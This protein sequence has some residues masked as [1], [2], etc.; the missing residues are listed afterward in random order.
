MSTLYTPSRYGYMATKSV[1]FSTDYSVKPIQV[2]VVPDLVVRVLATPIFFSGSV[3]GYC[4]PSACIRLGVVPVALAQLKKLQIAFKH[5]FNDT[6]EVAAGV[7]AAGYM[8]TVFAQG[9]S[10]LQ[11]I[12]GFPIFEAV[13]IIATPDKANEFLLYIPMVDNH[14]LPYLIEVMLKFFNHSVF[15]TTDLPDKALVLVMEALL[16]KLVSYAPKGS[17][18]LRFLQAAHFADIPWMFIEQN[19]FQFGYGKKS[20]WLDST[21]TDKTSILATQLARSKLSTA[22]LLRKAGL[23]VPDQYLVTSETEAINAAKKIGYPVVVKPLSEDNG[24]GVEARLQSEQ[25]VKKA[26]LGA[27][28]YSEQVVIEKHIMGKDYRLQVLHGELIWAIERIPAGITGDGKSTISTLLHALKNKEQKNSIQVNPIQLTEEVTEFLEEQGYGLESILPADQF[29][30]VSR[31][32]NISSGGTPV[33]VYDKVHPDNKRLAE[34]AANLLRLDIA[35][36]DLIM[37]DIQK[38][39]LEQDGAVIEVNAQPQLG[40]ITAPHIYKDILLKLL[41]EQG[42]IPIIGILGD[43]ISAALIEQMQQVLLSP[44]KMIGHAQANHA[45]IDGVTVAATDSLFTAG[46]ALLLNKTV[47]AL[48]YQAG[49][50]HELSVSGLPFDAFDCLFIGDESGFDLTE[51][52]WLKT[53]FKACR[54]AVITTEKTAAALVNLALV[55]EVRLAVILKQ[56][57]EGK[58]HYPDKVDTVSYWNENQQLVIEQVGR[59]TN[60][61]PVIVG[62]IHENLSALEQSFLALGLHYSNLAREA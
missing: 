8:A 62:K 50:L 17:N 41:P 23:P 54:G 21:F 19:V 14:Y 20:L 44:H 2:P 39:Y 60:S 16:N 46:R 34:T 30:P 58:R 42:R 22:I 10:A 52:P 49:N 32:A 38:S 4:Q 53:L 6:L 28:N 11:R 12:S 18:S 61:A 5:Y 45:R 51:T 47:E 56:T 29:V 48:I 7:D 59:T 9:L 57:P 26:Y 55:D 27:R 13:Q 35:G 43:S 25:A 31:I 40:S 37:P 15:S 33:G 3:Q 1:S 24:R 36:I